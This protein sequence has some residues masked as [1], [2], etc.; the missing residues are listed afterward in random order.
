MQIEERE[1]LE[2]ALIGYGMHLARIDQQIS[3]VRA[4]IRAAMWEKE[5]AINAAVASLY[6]ATMKPK[7][8]PEGAARI[9]AANRKR[10]AA[11]R[12]KAKASSP[13][14]RGLKAAKKA[15]RG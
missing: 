11:Y 6:R 13:V 7:L 14:A 1:V 2:M 9:A 5:K 12:L 8:S 15:G 3:E 10:W 4:R